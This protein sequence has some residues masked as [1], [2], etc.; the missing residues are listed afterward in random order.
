VAVAIENKSVGNSGLNNILTHLSPLNNTATNAGTLTT[1]ASTTAVI[2]FV[3]VASQTDVISA[4]KLGGVSASELTNSF[5]AFGAITSGSGSVRAFELK[6]PGAHA[7]GQIQVTQNSGGTLDCY[8]WAISY[9]GSDASNASTAWSGND[10]GSAKTQ[11]TTGA[12]PSSIPSTDQISAFFLNPVQGWQSNNTDY[13]CT[14]VTATTFV[15][16]DGALTNN[17]AAVTATGNNATAT[18]IGDN[19]GAPGTADFCCAVA[20]WVAVP[21]SGVVEN[22]AEYRARSFPFNWFPRLRNLTNYAQDQSSFGVETNPHWRGRAFPPQWSPLRALVQKS[23]PNTPPQLANPHWIGLPWPIQWKPMPLG[24]TTAQDFS[25]FGVET[26]PHWRGRPWPFIWQL[27]P[28]GRSVPTDVPFTPPDVPVY[29]QPR[30][31]P[32]QWKPLAALNQVPATDVPPFQAD[33]P[34]YFL[35]RTWPILWQ[36]NRAL[37]QTT[38]NDLSSTG[39]E[40]NVQFTPRT[41]ASQW[42]LQASLLRGTPQDFSSTAPVG[43]MQYIT[44]LG[45]IFNPNP[46]GQSIG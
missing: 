29:F 35:L 32:L 8:C 13:P 2:I 36:L 30:T 33:T 39:V 15:D 44:S 17:S 1:T 34:A 6:S 9:T 14:G 31:W 37:G 25:S 26:N 4:V 10:G 19:A 46:G 24:R 38:A 18:M 3:A 45:G 5:K 22:K 21:A 11:D 41:W 43:T 42:N 28:L 40:T 27:M 20:V 12:S 7:A 23:D 16:T